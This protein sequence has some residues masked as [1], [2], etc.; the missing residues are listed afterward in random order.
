M[1]HR[2]VSHPEREK[3]AAPVRSMVINIRTNLLPEELLDRMFRL[4]SPW[5]L[6][7]VLLVCIQESS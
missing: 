7:E 4:V 1:A 5:Q 3:M 6:L 2:G